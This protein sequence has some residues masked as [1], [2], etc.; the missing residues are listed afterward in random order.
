MTILRG[1][2]S[3]LMMEHTIENTTINILFETHKTIR[4]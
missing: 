3:S 2:K 4:E 1:Q